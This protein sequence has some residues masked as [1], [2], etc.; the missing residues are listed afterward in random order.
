[1]RGHSQ[2]G[3]CGGGC[4]KPVLP[5][6]CPWRVLEALTHTD[7]Q[8]VVPPLAHPPHTA[9][10]AGSSRS[11]ASRVLMEPCA[12]APDLTLVSL[13]LPPP[14]GALLPT[15]PAQ[16]LPSLLPLLAPP[17]R[18]SRAAGPPGTWISHVT[19]TPEASCSQPALQAPLGGPWATQNLG[20]PS[21]R[22]PPGLP[23]CVPPAV[24]P[25]HTRP[26]STTLPTLLPMMPSPGSLPPLGQPSSRGGAPHSREDS[27][28]WLTCCSTPPLKCKPPAGG[29]GPSARTSPSLLPGFS[30]RQSKSKGWNESGACGGDA[31]GHRAEQDSGPVS[32]HLQSCRGGPCASAQGSLG[33]AVS[34]PKPSITLSFS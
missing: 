13:P 17:H 4:E 10:L 26:L 22:S 8:A 34:S 6:H 14:L 33:T 30:G 27:V 2:G 5:S 23:G 28:R 7:K 24:S 19:L 9:P 3:F 12:G 11:R 15:L 32:Q 21:A 25:A 16:A 20:V 29:D 31:R 18:P 1:M